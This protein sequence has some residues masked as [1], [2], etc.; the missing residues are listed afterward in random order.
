MTTAAP[1]TLALNISWPP[2]SKA[3]LRLSAN[4]ASRPAP[5]TA[6]ATPPAT[7]W[8]RPATPRVTASTMPIIRPA[9]ITSRNTMMRAPSI[10]LLRDHD[11]LGRVGMELA[12]EFI[13]A[14][15]K[16]TDPNRGPGFA[17]DDL[18][19]LERGTI[20]LLRRGIFV[21]NAQRDALACG[22]PDFG[23]LEIVVPDNELEFLRPCTRGAR[24]GRVR[25]KKGPC[26]D[27]RRHQL[28]HCIRRL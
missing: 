19:H 13:T 3:L 15:A 25:G 18:L 6:I 26:K 27:D 4:T 10:A 1:S 17:G 12:H 5:S 11:A 24:D 8:P 22:N 14:G 9:S 2:P 28:C 16:R 7:H 20:E 21:A 23:R